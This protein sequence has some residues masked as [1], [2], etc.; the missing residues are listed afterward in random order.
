MRRD[1]R[2]TRRSDALSQRTD[3]RHDNIVNPLKLR[4]KRC[5]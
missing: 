2:K 3:I 5:R 4:M 1:S